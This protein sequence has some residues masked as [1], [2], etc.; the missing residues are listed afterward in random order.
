MNTDLTDAVE[1]AETAARQAG[2]LLLTMRGKIHPREKAPADL[3]TEADVASQQL[4]FECLSARFPD[5]AFLGEEDSNVSRS[6]NS[7]YRWIVD[8][9]DGTTNY[10]HGLENYCVSIGLQRQD[11]QI[12]AGVIYDPNRD[13]VYSAVRGSGAFQNGQK[14]KTSP[15]RRLDQALVAA[16][17]P[18]KVAR[19]SAEIRRF[20]EVLVRCQAL[21]R[22]GSAALNMCFVAAGRLDA[23]WATS[24]KTWDVAAGLLIIEESGGVVTDLNGHAVDLERP[25]I[26]V[27][28]TPELQAELAK[29]LRI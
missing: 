19:D 6:F 20:V 22:L 15:V 24:V 2:A 25:R 29:V 17:F 14:L 5:F 9:L 23:Y 11:G 13:I 3:V 28:A 12:A 26:V 1:S 18:A 21:R 16:S 7:D 10:V 8:P 27:G 4:I